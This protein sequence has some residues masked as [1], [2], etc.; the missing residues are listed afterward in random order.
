MTI[1]FFHFFFPPLFS[2]RFLKERKE[3]KKIDRGKGEVKK[4]KIDKGRKE[5]V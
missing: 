3:K 5:R 4:E 2:H 1:F